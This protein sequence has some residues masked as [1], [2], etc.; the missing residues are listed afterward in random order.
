MPL[1]PKTPA[2]WTRS[3]A[4]PLLATCILVIM[5]LLAGGFSGGR[6]WRYW[7]TPIAS[8]LLPLL[9]LSLGLSCLCGTGLSRGFRI[10]ALIIAVL[11]VLFGPMLGPGYAE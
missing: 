8:V 10:L 11:S 2:E 5:A 3:F 9:G 7:G 1:I 6:E 4:V